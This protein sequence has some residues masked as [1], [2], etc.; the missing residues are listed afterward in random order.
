MA[1]NPKIG[2][3]AH[4]FDQEQESPSRRFARLPKQRAALVCPIAV[5]VVDGQKLI[6][7]LT[8]TG[9]LISIMR[10]YLSTNALVVSFLRCSYTV[11]M[12]KP[13]FPRTL[14]ILHS[15]A[16]SLFRIGALLIS[17]VLLVLAPFL[18]RAFQ[19][20]LLPQFLVSLI[21]SVPILAALGATFFGVHD[22]II[23]QIA[24]AE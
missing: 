22:S 10:K 14:S 9:A 3:I 21:V 5:N 24:V 17:P 16:G 19:G 8:T 20:T 1:E 15:E 18:L 11:R 2:R 23:P 7:R 13:K 12:R 4:P 6:R